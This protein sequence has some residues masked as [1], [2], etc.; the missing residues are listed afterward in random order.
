MMFT[1]T[2][3]RLCAGML[4][5]ER[6]IWRTITI[7]ICEK[8]FITNMRLAGEVRMSGRHIFEHVKTHLTSTDIDPNFIHL[9]FT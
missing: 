5:G 6:K 2:Q 8:F 7:E 1:F 9:Q 4:W 3:D